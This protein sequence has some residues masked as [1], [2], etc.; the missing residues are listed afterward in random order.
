LL[1]SE[2]EEVFAVSRSPHWEDETTTVTARLASGR[3]GFTRT[4]CESCSGASEDHSDCKEFCA[5]H[6][7]T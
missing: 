4:I 2:I 1:Q 6:Q 5:W 3:V 7:Q